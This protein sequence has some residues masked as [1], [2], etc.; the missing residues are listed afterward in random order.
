MSRN[1]PRPPVL[2]VDTSGLDDEQHQDVFLDTRKPPHQVPIPPFQVSVE[3]A[4]PSS[5]IIPPPLS[6]PPPPST[7]SQLSQN[8]P[9]ST[10]VDR[11]LQET[12]KLLTHILSQLQHRPMPP[13]IFDDVNSSTKP[14]KYKN[15]RRDARAQPQLAQGEDDDDDYES[16]IFTTD[17]TYDLMLQLKEVL[18]QFSSYHCSV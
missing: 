13:S 17:T 14:V 11:A 15:N 6:I 7:V 5:P 10:I 2:R 4:S 18:R 9:S 1:A 8:V 12:R 3:P 16:D